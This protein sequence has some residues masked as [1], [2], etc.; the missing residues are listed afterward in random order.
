MSPPPKLLVM[1]IGNDFRRDDGAGR[2]IARHVRAAGLPGVVVEE[3]TRDVADMLQAW[4][5]FDT[6][7]LA[8]AV[9][10]GAPPGTVFRFDAGKGPLPEIFGRQVSSHGMGPAEA[11]ELAR[12]LGELPGRMIV[13]G[14]E[15]ADF[16]DGTEISAAVIRGVGDVAQELMKFVK[17]LPDA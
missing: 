9:C 2:E 15:G 10:S 11:I 5:D 4:S 1:G 12:A 3:H 6:V 16:G 13:Y 8:D 7:I 17:E 14:V